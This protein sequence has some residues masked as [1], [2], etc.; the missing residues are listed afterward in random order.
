MISKILQKEV[1]QWCKSVLDDVAI[2]S[3]H[4]KEHG[5]HKSNTFRLR[6][7][8]GNCYLKI[9][10]SR[11]HWQNEV[12]AYTR[13]ASVFGKHAPRLLAVRDETPLAIIV[14]ELQGKVVEHVTLT[15]DQEKAVWRSAGALLLRLH[16]L[17]SGTHF[18]AILKD[19]SSSV[20]TG[21]QKYMSGKL[22][23]QLEHALQEGYLDKKEVSTIQTA[24]DLIP[25]FE[26]EKPLPC[27]RDYCAANWLVDTEGN[28]VG[29]IDFEFAY[30]DVRVADFSRDPDWSWMIKPELICAFFEGYGRQLTEQEEVQRFIAYVDYAL[31][32]IIWGRENAFFGFEREGRDA[33]VH[34]STQITRKD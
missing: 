23:K 32:A 19:K 21:A 12:Q 25:A 26:G 10:E 15:P 2:L 14:S 20:I 7:S 31:S 5:G 22:M 3:D 13:W 18:G 1:F 6:S 11:F 28:W 24:L 34:L 8:K 17:E 33:L 27:H 29:V 4:S 16:E 30:W 9:H